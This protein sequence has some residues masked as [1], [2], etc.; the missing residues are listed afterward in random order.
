MYTY[1]S[2]PWVYYV[3]IQM[4]T[5]PYVAVVGRVRNNALRSQRCRAPGGHSVGL[6]IMTQCIAAA[7]SP[8]LF[9]AGPARKL[10]RNLMFSHSSGSPPG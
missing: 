5:S 2:E 1:L 8:L 3:K 9:S 4:I 7:A 6:L 10:T